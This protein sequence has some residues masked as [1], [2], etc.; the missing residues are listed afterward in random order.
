MDVHELSIG[1]ELEANVIDID[2]GKAS[3][4]FNNRAFQKFQ[5]IF[6]L[7]AIPRFRR[8]LMLLQLNCLPCLITIWI[9]RF[10]TFLPICMLPIIFIA[11]RILVAFVRFASGKRS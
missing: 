11:A 3:L 5:P 1:L 9:W 6:F 8:S 7:R 2:T 10:R 4:D